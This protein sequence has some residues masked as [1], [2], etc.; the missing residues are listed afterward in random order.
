MKGAEK[1]AGAKEF[2]EDI[3]TGRLAARYARRGDLKSLDPNPLDAESGGVWKAGKKSKL[4]IYTP[5]LTKYGDEGAM[6][7]YVSSAEKNIEAARLYQENERTAKSNQMR[8]DFNKQSWKN[9]GEDG[10]IQKAEDNATN[11]NTIKAQMEKYKGWNR[12]VQ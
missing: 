1:R 6:Y 3:K 12:F 2:R 10:Y 7:D 9:Y 5:D 8:A 11:R 4:K